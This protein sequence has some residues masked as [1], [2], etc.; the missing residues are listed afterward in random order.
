MVSEEKYSRVPRLSRML[1]NYFYCP[2]C[3]GITVHFALESVSSLPWTGRPVWSGIR[4]L[5][6]AKRIGAI[7]WVSFR[8]YMTLQGALK[9]ITHITRHQKRN[10]T[11]L[12]GY[13]RLN[14][15][16]I[17]GLIKAFSPNFEITLVNQRPKI[18]SC[19]HP[20]VM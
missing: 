7:R 9:D 4:K 3:R 18:S 14:A 2:V 17:K 1:R 10:L 15:R 19:Q 5:A 11:R 20:E 6:V 12:T 8:Y 13:Y 16:V